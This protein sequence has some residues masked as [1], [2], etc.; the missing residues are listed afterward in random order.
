MEKAETMLFKSMEE[1]K[2]D[3]GRWQ[4]SWRTIQITMY[5]KLGE[6]MQSDIAAKFVLEGEG[7]VNEGW[8][9]VPSGLSQIW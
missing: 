4:A 5:A 1:A 6:E 7:C 2:E 8:T 9:I 3:L